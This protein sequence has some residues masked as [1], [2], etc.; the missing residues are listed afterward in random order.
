VNILVQNPPNIEEIKKT[1]DIEG[2]SPVFTYGDTLY[3]PSNISLPLD[4]QIHESI[5]AGQ[6][7]NNQT[8]AKLWWSRYLQDS[9]FRASQEIEAYGAQYT[10][11]RTKIKDRNKLDL[12]LREMAKMLSGKMYGNIISFSEALKAIKTQATK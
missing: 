3:N 4:L 2:I 12:Y 7:E 11:L 9:D 1:F 10:F 6:Q 8:V 5:H